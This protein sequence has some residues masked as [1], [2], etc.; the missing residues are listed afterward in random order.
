MSLADWA[1]L[2]VIAGVPTVAYQL[3]QTRRQREEESRRYVV[4]DLEAYGP[5][6]DLVV[7]NSGQTAATE[8][9]ITIE[10]ELHGDREASL[11]EALADL[12]E[13]RNS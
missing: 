12:R 10:A 2:A 9:H 1:N 13:G 5:R 4:V 3:F 11:S 7:R 8:A 6:L